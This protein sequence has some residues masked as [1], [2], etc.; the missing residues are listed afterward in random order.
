MSTSLQNSLDSWLSKL[1]GKWHPDP[2]T[3]IITIVIAPLGYLILRLLA[4]SAAIWTK[5]FVEGVLYWISRYIT[6]SM[7][8]QLTLKRYCRL[9]LKSDNRFLY[10]PSRF[11]IKL[12]VDDIFV[13]L[14]LEQ[15][16]GL[17]AL[18][19]HSTLFQIGNRL[20][21]M[22]DP[23]SGKSSLVKKI[24]RDECAR[25]LASPSSPWR[26]PFFLSDG[27]MKDGKHQIA[28]E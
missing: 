10:V 8:A 11:D 28:A 20:R 4:K 1:P 26:N 15:H 18:H 6:R 21:I 25:A 13:T 17:S 27:Q 16:G 23:G 2:T 7:A 24:F 5:H 22:G 3:A 9:Q 14:R 19:T 12:D